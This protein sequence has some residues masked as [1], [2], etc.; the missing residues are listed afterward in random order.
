MFGRKRCAPPRLPLLDVSRMAVD[1]VLDAMPVAAIV[2]DVDGRLVY[3][4]AA[5]DR[6]FGYPDLVGCHLQALI[7]ERSRGIHVA[8]RTAYQLDPTPKPMGPDREVWALRKDGTEFRCEIGLLPLN[9][10]LTAAV[11]HRVRD[12]RPGPLNPR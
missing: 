2:A 8:H 9:H 7:P 5:A 1:T 10:H 11:I 4:N 12:Q 6:M 3:A